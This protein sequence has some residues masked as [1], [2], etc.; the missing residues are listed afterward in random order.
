M[1]RNKNTDPYRAAIMCA[2]KNS[3]RRRSDAKS[4]AKKVF[5]SRFYQDEHAGK[6]TGRLVAYK[7]PFCGQFHIGHDKRKA[8]GEKMNILEDGG[9]N[10]GGI[11]PDGIL[12]TNHNSKTGHWL[13]LELIGAE[14]RARN[15]ISSGT[16]DVNDLTKNVIISKIHEWIKDFK[17]QSAT[18]Q[19]E[20]PPETNASPVPPQD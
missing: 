19:D 17:D 2:G 20:T 15:A 3:F 16:G 11:W 7:C 6:K 12:V 10:V 1:S 14:P 9:L 13:E 18:R 5:N 4:S 8:K